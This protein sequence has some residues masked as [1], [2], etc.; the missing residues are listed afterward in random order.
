MPLAPMLSRRAVGYARVSTK[1]QAAPD[2]SSLQY[3]EQDIRRLV[4]AWNLQLDALWFEVASGG[5]VRLRRVYCEMLA[6]CY[7]NPQPRD[8]MGVI[9]VA[10]YSRFSRMPLAMAI[11][12]RHDL[13]EHG[14]VVRGAREELEPTESEI[15]LR[16]IFEAMVDPRAQQSVLLGGRQ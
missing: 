7:S 12:E 6:Y 10:D 4:A 1:A 9:V 14:W 2:R 13:A 8:R 3:Q 11:Q 16:E 15:L 5:T